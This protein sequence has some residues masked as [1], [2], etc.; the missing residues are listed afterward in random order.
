MLCKR[1]RV[2]QVNMISVNIGSMRWN[3]VACDFS[4]IEATLARRPLLKKLN[5]CFRHE[6]AYLCHIVIFIGVILRTDKVPCNK[7]VTFQ[8]NEMKSTKFLTKKM[9]KLTNLSRTCS[10]RKNFEIDS[11][12][13]KRIC[14]VVAVWFNF[15]A[16]NRCQYQKA[17]RQISFM[18]TWTESGHGKLIK[19]IILSSY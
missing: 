12:S 5:W 1:C 18:K 19:L 17:L 9:L 3:V 16:S 10:I 6:W 2:E 14:H 7:A 11:E 4:C 15:I 8:L 13:I